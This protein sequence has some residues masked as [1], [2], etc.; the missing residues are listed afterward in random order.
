MSNNTEREKIL[1]IILFI[2]GLSNLVL[3]ILFSFFS[4]FKEINIIPLTIGFSI[5][6]SVIIIYSIGKI[7]NKDDK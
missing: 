1:T 3:G 5:T 7:I 2:Y 6:L 4:I